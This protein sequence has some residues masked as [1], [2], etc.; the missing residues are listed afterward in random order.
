MRRI[1]L[2]LILVTAALLAG[3]V[4]DSYRSRDRGYVGR[5]EG[6]YDRYDGYRG[7]PYGPRVSIGLQYGRGYFG[8][9]YCDPF[10]SP[11]RAGYLGCGFGGYSPFGYG[12]YYGGPA[13]HLGLH[14]GGGWYG[15]PWGFYS[16]YYGYGSPYYGPYWSPGHGSSH[17]SRGF[18][19]QDRYGMA[20]DEAA[21][22]QRQQSGTRSRVS[23]DSQGPS[24]DNSRGTR[25]A[26]PERSVNRGTVVPSR[27]ARSPARPA[28]PDGAE[29][30]LD[31]E[32]RFDRFQSV[33]TT[34]RPRSGDASGWRRLGDARDADVRVVRAVEPV[35]RN[36]PSAEWAQQRGTFPVRGLTPP[37]AEAPAPSQRVVRQ[38][39]FFERQRFQDATPNIPASAPPG[40]GQ[41]QLTYESGRSTSRESEQGSDERTSRAT[42]REA[43]ND[44]PPPNR[45]SVRHERRGRER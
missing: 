34:P 44:N 23:S 31:N 20:N 42:S 21:R 29:A 6:V 30:R 33:T 18:Y 10:Y 11:Y 35:R 17:V 45:E 15:R 32:A 28:R 4:T 24:S 43:S 5:Y 40:A 2:A 38:A 12:G 9:R 7:G 36:D 19:Q 13:F 1:H 26:G 22:L 27:G 16:P 8:S 37:A 3:C 39:E 25:R 14:Y 41:N